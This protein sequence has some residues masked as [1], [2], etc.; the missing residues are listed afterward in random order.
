FQTGHIARRIDLGLE[1]AALDQDAAETHRLVGSAHVFKLSRLRLV[2]RRKQ[3]P[4][5][6]E[7]TNNP[8]LRDQTLDV[9]DPV[10][11]HVERL[12]R[13]LRSRFGQVVP[14]AGHAGVAKASVTPA[15]AVAAAGALKQHDL[16]VRKLLYEMV[17]G[18]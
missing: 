10:E 6:F 17:G 13:G 12:A 4:V 2:N 1:L 7:V 3:H 15:R 14:E 18:G 8:V 11:G 16:L 5:F 9:S